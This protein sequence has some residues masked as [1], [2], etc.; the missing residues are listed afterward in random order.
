MGPSGEEDHH[1][2]HQRGVFLSLS[3]L[4]PATAMDNVTPRPLRESLLVANKLTINQSHPRKLE[5]R[6]YHSIFAC[7]TTDVQANCVA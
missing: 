3:A 5:T 2:H 7:L 6:I 4:N 1:H